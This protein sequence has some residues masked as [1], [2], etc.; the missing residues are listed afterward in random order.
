MKKY[1]TDSYFLSELLDIDK[2]LA[3]FY[4]NSIN[5]AADEFLSMKGVSENRVKEI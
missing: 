5:Q 4:W 1:K 2:A 3:D